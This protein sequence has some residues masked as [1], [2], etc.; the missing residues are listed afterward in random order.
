M[1]QEDSTM[2]YVK[3]IIAVAMITLMVSGIFHSSS[4]SNDIR[5]SIGNGLGCLSVFWAALSI[6]CFGVFRKQFV[7]R[8]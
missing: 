3:G 4:S 8:N 1:G 7:L 2:R 5:Y 6:A